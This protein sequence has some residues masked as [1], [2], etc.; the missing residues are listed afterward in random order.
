MN[1]VTGAE[2][3][4]DRELA[5]DVCV[6]GTG[7]GGAVLAAGL[8]ARGLKVVVIEAGGAFTR[9]DWAA[10]EERVSLPMLYQ[11]RGSRATADQ[12]ITI[13]QGRNLGGGTTVNWTTCF[14]TPAR[15][16]DHWR[17][18]HRIEGWD[19][20]SLAP[21]FEAVEARLGIAPWDEALLNGN[22][23]KLRRGV[24]AQGGKAEVLRRN[25]RGCA[26]SGFC[27]LGCPVDA[28]QAMH[29]TYLP[30]ASAAGALF[31]VDVNVERL[32]HDGRRVVAAHGAVM[33]R[34]RDRPTGRRLTVRADRFALCGGAINSPALLLASG[35]DRPPVGR[36]TF[37]HP[38]VAVAGEYAEPVRAWQGAP[39]SVA[40]HDDVDRGPDRIGYFLEAAPLH[41]M[42]GALAARLAGPAAAAFMKRLP[43]L[44]THIALAVDGLME[45][46]E[47]GTV[48]VRSD[49]RPRVDYP[50]G[51]ALI[52]AMRAGTE[53]LLRA[54]L[55]AG[56][57]AAQTLHVEP[58]RV[59]NAR[60]LK[61]AL[62]R[63]FGALEHAIFSAHQMGGCAMGPDP[64]TSV[65][66]TQ[67]RHHD[68]DNLWVV[69][70]SVFPTALGVNPSES[71]YALADR[72]VGWV[73]G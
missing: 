42:L 60:E 30:D 63:P 62:D 51:P 28:K 26:N 43:Y 47:G 64:A 67:L 19:E 71:I 69:D 55:A 61:K 52:E 59:T 57:V 68:A 40:S 53:D 14:R 15:I 37:L 23:S 31:H 3:T 16:L 17:T 34:T 46:D 5:A 48:T 12:A 25:V 20:A 27:G 11:E 35:L 50:V 39:Q 36:R 4:A 44:T 65:V 10:G 58:A 8:A 54:N 9:A 24:R 73:A 38:V 33:E 56:A 45:G 72:A 2:M 6:I 70:G 29:L 18:R 41:P 32:E 49:G 66:N 1:V 7:A 13:L 22:N 21:H